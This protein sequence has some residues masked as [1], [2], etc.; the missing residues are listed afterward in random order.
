MGK[1]ANAVYVISQSAAAGLLYELGVNKENIVVVPDVLSFGRVLPVTD[2]G[3]WYRA[4]KDYWAHV[5]S[6]VG[7]V[8]N[9][10]DN[11]SNLLEIRNEFSEIEEL[12]F[13]VEPTVD[14]GLSFIW[15]LSVFL[16]GG[17]ERE[18]LRYIAGWP[19][20]G[21]RNSSLFTSYLSSINKIEELDVAKTM[22]DESEVLHLR[23]MFDVVSAG[24]P[25]MLDN[26]RP[27]STEFVSLVSRCVNEL[28]FRY[29]DLNTGLNRFDLELLKICSD[30]N[31]GVAKVVSNHVINCQGGYD[32]PGDIVARSRLA[33]M[34]SS[35]KV[36][37]LLLVSGDIT[38][39]RTASID[40]TEAGKKVLDGSADNVKLN[41]VDEWVGGV[42]LQ[43]PN[44]EMWYRD[45]GKLIKK[46]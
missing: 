13:C 7:E 15:A 34:A 36:N 33:G 20:E 19:K 9:V 5:E 22:F 16:E 14:G 11:Y 41:G 10:P 23:E 28:V 2:F 39:M 1:S 31:Q 32:S 21:V 37:P 25:R 29:P 12:T 42:N 24:D 35:R 4:R 43:H 46:A 26:L 17:I 38:D 18:K 3:D 27:A 8:L 44:G 40:I 30:G 6:L 45:D